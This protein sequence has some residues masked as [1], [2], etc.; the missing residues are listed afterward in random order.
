MRLYA[1]SE[2]HSG[3]DELS[4]NSTSRHEAQTCELSNVMANEGDLIVRAEDAAFMDGVTTLL[5]KQKHK[6]K[7]KH[8]KH[9]SHKKAKHSSSRP[10]LSARMLQAK[11][12]W[13]ETGAADLEAKV[14][15][16]RQLDMRTATGDLSLKVFLTSFFAPSSSLLRK[17]SGQMPLLAESGERA[18]TSGSGADESEAQPYNVTIINE[19]GMTDLTYAY[20]LPGASLFT[21]VLTSTAPQPL[22]PGANSSA[23]HAAA[24]HKTDKPRV[25]I[26]HGP[27]WQGDVSIGLVGNAST[28]STSGAGKGK[29]GKSK[30]NSS[31]IR[32]RVQRP[33]R[34][35]LS[36]VDD[37]PGGPGRTSR[38]DA[39]THTARGRVWWPEE[40]ATKRWITNWGR[41]EVRQVSF[42][43]ER[44]RNARKDGG[45]GPKEGTLVELAFPSREDRPFDEL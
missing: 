16:A 11:R 22:A 27:A 3:D 32:M 42:D 9:K 8:K 12:V 35:S 43:G 40:E 10:R 6:Q 25:R 31:P 2:S 29:K 41:T 28:T 34:F 20:Q 26:Q 23:G 5:K 30:S 38:T 19:L 1:P 36:D 17:R 39:T 14:T 7:K 18:G 37:E 24:G 21:R 33:K 45:A 13:V 15:P 4:S 44:A